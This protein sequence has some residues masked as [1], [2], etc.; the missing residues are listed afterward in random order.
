MEQQQNFRRLTLYFGLFATIAAGMIGLG[1]HSWNLPLLVGF[2]SAVS[3]VYTD[4]LGWFSLHRWLVYV[5]MIGGAALAIFNFMSDASANQIIAVGNLLVY[6]QIPLM[7]QKKSKRVFEQWGVF[8]LLELVVAALVNDNVLYGVLMLPVLA[9]GCAALMALAQF[10]SHLRHSESI[11]ESTTYWARVLHW[12][13][14]EQLVTKRSSGV[15]LSA[16]PVV[17]SVSKKSEPFAPSKWM[18]GILPLAFSVLLFAV[19][20][21]YALPRLS[22]SSYDGDG[23]GTPQVGFNEQISLRHIGEMLQDDTP[24]FRMSMK[25]SKTQRNYRPITPPYIRMSVAHKYFEGPSKG[26]WDRAE[27]GFFIDPRL[28]RPIASTSEIDDALSKESDSVTVSIVEKSSFGSVVPSIPPHSVDNPIKEFQVIRKDWRIIDTRESAR[29]Q[30]RKRRYSYNTY[31]FVNGQDSAI[32]PEIND[33]LRDEDEHGSSYMSHY[34]GRDLLE[35]PVSLSSVLPFRDRVLS[36]SPVGE[37]DKLSQAILLEDYLANGPDFTYTLSLTGPINKEFDPIVDFLL[38]KRKGHCQYFASSL[39][40]LLRSLDIPT[41][42]VV[43]YRPSEY[44][45]LGQYFLVQQNHAHV[46]V[47]AY[48][49]KEELRA[50]FPTQLTAVT[51]GAWLRLDPTPAG[52][53]SNAGGT[54]RRSSGETLD[55]MQDLWSEMVLNMDKSKQ[56]SILS[57]FGESSSGSYTSIWLQVQALYIRM[58]SSRFIGGFLSPEKWFSWRQALAIIAI[59]SA[60]VLLYRG[61]LWLFPTWM[62]K[63]RWRTSRTKSKTSTVDFYNRVIKSLKRLG[64]RRLGYQTQQEFFQLAETQLAAMAIPLDADLLSRSFYECRFGGVTKLSETEQAKIDESIQTL[65]AKATLWKRT[66]RFVEQ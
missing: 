64:I 43:G 34:H 56:S 10:A 41:R 47:E 9:I 33:C 6:V 26:A 38:A 13:G 18:R 20:Y 46:W 28:M 24:V 39:A 23:W 30:N 48:F 55:V 11:S 3:I 8:M 61:L 35:F 32:L 15:T 65:E 36:L 12:L 40:L 51:R 7:F 66:K 19:A 16:I 57:L 29:T 62:P 4:K 22:S 14:K 58:Q 27:S 60:I 59:G 21:F 45:E 25:D 37:R 1:Q 63:I 52:E 53:G 2:C 42:I 44:N 31:A 5:G 54:L 49:T 50:R 17:A